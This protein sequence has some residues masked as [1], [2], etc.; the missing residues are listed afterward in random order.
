MVKKGILWSGWWIILILLMCNFSLAVFGQGAASPLAALVNWKLPLPVGKYLIIQGDKND[1]E[2][3]THKSDWLAL[4]CAIDIV[5][6]RDKTSIDGTPLLS[7]AAGVVV[8]AKFQ[9]E[10][11]YYLT[12]KH[13]DG[14]FS[15][16]MHLM[17][18]SFSVREGDRVRQGQPLALV[19]NTGKTSESHVHFVVLT[20]DRKDCLFMTELDGNTNFKKNA[21]IYSTNQQIGSAPENPPSYPIPPAPPLPTLSQS[22][23]TDEKCTLNRIESYL[24]GSPLAKLGSTFIAMGRKYNVDPRFIIAITNAESSLGRKLCAPYNAW[25]EM[26]S[27]GGGCISFNSWDEAI[28]FVSNHIGK[29]YLPVGQTNIASFVIKPAGTCSSHC[30]C[31][32][33]CQNWIPNVSSAYQAMGGDPN[34]NNLIFLGCEGAES[35]LPIGSTPST[36]DATKPDSDYTSP[37]NG[38]SVDCS[39]HLAAWARDDQSGVK[40]VHFTAKWNNQWGLVYNDRSAPY[41]YTWDICAAGVPNGDIELGLDVYDKA[42]NEFN[43]STKHA[44]PHITKN[45]TVTATTAPLQAPVIPALREPAKSAFLPSNTNIWFSWYPVEGASQYYMEYWGGAYG[46]LNSQ[47]IYDTAHHIGTMWPGTYSWHVKARNTSGMESAWSQTWSFTIQETAVPTTP[48][49]PPPAADTTKPDGDY[50]SPSNGATVGC[51]V[52]LAAWASDNQSGVKEVHFTAKR[53]NQWSLV[54]NDTSAPYEYDWNLCNANVPNGD[55]ELGL[56]VYDKSGNEFNL[57]T[58]HTNIHITKNTATPTA[59]P[60]PPPST[61][62][63]IA[64]QANRNPDGIGSASA[65]DG[66]LSTFWTDGLGHGFNL[67]LSW[68][69]SL[70]VTRIIVWDRPQN[71][72]DNNQINAIIITLSNGISKRFGMDSMNSRCIAVAFSSPQTINSIT[73]IADDASG[74]NGLS[75]VEIWVGSKSGGP[76]CSNTGSMP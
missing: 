60:P 16:I 1:T 58:K 33:G 51:T 18:D 70:P 28:E 71:S 49:P 65:F 46:T 66:N 8:D 63:N 3:S 10:A 38:A 22:A 14:L 32:S 57:H 52:H 37:S 39:V 25:G 2:S 45:A 35:S 74:N 42:G 72:P 5:N 56:D 19:G 6:P 53:N 43:L 29:Y 75:E 76:S 4:K 27:G 12:I 34:T 50:T 21:F 61:T 64:P 73:L 41:E 31:A 11:G 17:K 40:E 62:G 15:Q 54:Y 26:K 69:D 67:K 36:R 23:S 24:Q 20:S 7:P 68:G 47:W 30:W 9:G 59:P 44:N 55:I 48:A 13:D